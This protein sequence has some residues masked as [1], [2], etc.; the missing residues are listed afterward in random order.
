MSALKSNILI[1]D[2]IE[3]NRFVLQSILDHLDINILIADNGDQALQQ[4]LQHEFAVILLDVEMPGID[5]YETAKLIHGK[6]TFRDVPIVM[7]TASDAD[8]EQTLKAYQCGAVDYITKPV[9]PIVLIN[10][11]KQ[12]VKL[13]QQTRRAQTLQTQQQQA[14]ARLQVLL[15]SAGEGIVG[16]DLVGCISFANP[17]ACELLQTGLDK[18]IGKNI[19]DFYYTE[20]IGEFA[21]NASGNFQHRDLFTASGANRTGSERWITASGQSFFVEYSCEITTN[22]AG[23]KTGAVVMFQDVSE[24]RAIEER[25]IRLANYDPLTNLANR[26]YFQDSLERAVA[27]ALR[28]QQQLAIFFLDLDRFKTINDSLGHDAGDVLLK[29]V[30]ERLSHC[31]RAG[32]VAARIGG[33][34]FAIIL[35]DIASVVAISSIAEK[36]IA[37]VQQPLTLNGKQ[38]TTSTSIGISVFDNLE[39]STNDLV[40]AAD[41]AMYY[42]KEQGRNNYQFFQSRMQKSAEEKSRIQS[43]LKRALE[44]NELSVY[45]Q[46]KISTDGDKLIGMEALLRWQTAEG[47]IIAPSTF[48]PIAEDSG[49]IHELGSFVMKQVCKQIQSWKTLPSFNNLS[50]SINISALQLKAGDFHKTV[51]NSLQEYNID[52]KY[53]ELELTETAVMSNPEH[54]ITELQAIHDLGVR[55]AID[56]FGTGYS[57]L[58][59]LKRFP[60]DILKIDR[61]FVKDIGTDKYDEEIIKVMV[62][63]ANAM[64]IQVIAEGV[65]TKQQLAFL[66]SIGCHLI[67]GY[68]F[69]PALKSADITALLNQG[70]NTYQPMFK[71]L[72]VYMS[73]HNITIHNRPHLQ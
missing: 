53:I 11:V 55:I 14:N 2:D 37:T 44:Q 26:A 12:F 3:A 31:I 64:G 73:S 65:E 40:K 63:I 21:L 22:E 4:V 72:A 25:L 8:K 67:Q 6:K 33:D 9:E 58:N 34:E 1:V 51:Y 27:R 52:A 49:Q 30:G 5:G 48:V 71:E 47:L 17:K 46:P 60:I 36:V 16:T 32:D 45:Y 69:S 56:D 7:V 13:D 50:I 23:D 66:S 41:T 57:S 43:T 42:A 62:A 10:K 18:I 59:Y 39:M 20:S 68:Y 29:T 35:H 70:D 15:N 38:I 28:T 54:A 24:R 61:C 19:A